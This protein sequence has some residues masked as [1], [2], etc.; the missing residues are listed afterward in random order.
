MAATIQNAP[1]SLPT[2]QETVPGLIPSSAEDVITE[3][4]YLDYI[5]LNT[6]SSSATVTISDKQGTAR[7]ICH[8]NV[9]R[10]APVRI[11]MDGRLCPGGISWVASVDGVVVAYLR[12]RK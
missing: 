7:E 12:W 6:E 1:T 11:P 10:G 9:D 8:V 4:V 2:A 3:T 5:Q